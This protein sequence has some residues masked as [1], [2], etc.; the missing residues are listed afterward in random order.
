[1]KVRLLPRQSRVST[2]TV[3]ERG[4]RQG[5]TQKQPSSAAVARGQVSPHSQSE[6]AAYSGSAAADRTRRQ[7]RQ[8]APHRVL[9]RQS[10]TPP[11]VGS[12][13]WKRRPRGGRSS[14]SRGRFSGDPGPRPGFGDLFASPPE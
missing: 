3:Q 2:R 7:Q 4:C 11:L 6:S 5:L 1:M 13:V 8:A 14:D 10:E 12:T 9:L